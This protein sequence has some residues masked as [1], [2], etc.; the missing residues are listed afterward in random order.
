MCFT[1]CTASKVNA[2]SM[3][4]NF[5][6]FLLVDIAKDQARSVLISSSVYSI[7]QVIGLHFPAGYT[8]STWSVAT[9]KRRNCLVDIKQ[10]TTVSRPVLLASNQGETRYSSL[11]YYIYEYLQ[12]N[13]ILALI[14]FFSFRSLGETKR[15]IGACTS[16]FVNKCFNTY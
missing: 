12:D 6:W 15:A 13:G 5:M 1:A 9:I 16:S 4:N 10:S 8:A 14:I 7:P 3:V 2:N 11:N